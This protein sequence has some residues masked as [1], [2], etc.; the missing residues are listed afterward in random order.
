MVGGRVDW[1][2][3]IRG[4]GSGHEP[5]WVR[6][7]AGIRR[8]GH[9][10]ALAPILWIASRSASSDTGVSGEVRVVITAVSGGVL[11]VSGC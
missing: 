7:S 4:M 1:W 10:R 11:Q 5:T 8:P 6:G 2:L 9:L 3:L